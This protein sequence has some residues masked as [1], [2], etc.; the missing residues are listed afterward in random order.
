MRSLVALLP[1]R[2]IGYGSISGELTSGCYL[3]SIQPLGPR[4]RP[5]ALGKDTIVA[6]AGINRYRF[7]I[8]N[9]PVS[10]V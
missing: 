4:S 1:V 10:M 2:N 3:Y 5:F 8:L 7:S 6:T 9:A